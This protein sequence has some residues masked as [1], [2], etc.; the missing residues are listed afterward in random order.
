MTLEARDMLTDMGRD[1]WDPEHNP[2]QM[3]GVALLITIL[4]MPG[5]PKGIDDAMAELNGLRQ[6]MS[7]DEVRNIERAIRTY[8]GERLCQRC[9]TPAVGIRQYTGPHITGKFCPSCKAQLA[10]AC[11]FRGR[12]END[13]RRGEG[14]E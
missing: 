6:L 4:D 5:G 9:L 11:R 8:H 2:R 13:L 10:I 1:P 3:L 12:D 14:P 7:P